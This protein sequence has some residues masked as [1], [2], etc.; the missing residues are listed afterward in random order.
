MNQIKILNMDKWLEL[1]NSIRDRLSAYKEYGYGNYLYDFRSFNSPFNDDFDNL[2]FQSA[3]DDYYWLYCQMEVYKRTLI[4]R[5]ELFKN[6]FK[7]GEI[8]D[9]TEQE[10]KRYEKLKFLNGYADTCGIKAGDSYYSE[11]TYVGHKLRLICKKETFEQIELTQNKKIKYLNDLKEGNKF[12]DSE[13]GK[14]DYENCH[15]NRLQ[16]VVHPLVANQYPR[17]FIEGEYWQLFNEWKQELNKPDDFS[18]IYRVMYSDGFIHAGIGQKEFKTWVES[19]FSIGDLGK[20]LKPLLNCSS[21]P[22]YV[23]YQEKINKFQLHSK[24]LQKRSANTA[25]T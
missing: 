5:F 4:D 1:E 16:N 9:F 20:Q 3:N 8:S 10:L 14:S 21:K 18:F 19:T 12:D 24:T 22:K 6:K 13:V 23:L 11:Y 2:Y 7:D 25:K 17:I 15:N